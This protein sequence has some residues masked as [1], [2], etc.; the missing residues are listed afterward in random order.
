MRVHWWR[1]LLDHHA[2]CVSVYPA[3]NFWIPEQIFMKLG[4]YHDIW[5]HLNG[6]LGKSF[7]SVSV[8]ICVSLLSLLGNG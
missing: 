3:I 1:G 6:V 7:P 5:A 4:L 2:V 8:S